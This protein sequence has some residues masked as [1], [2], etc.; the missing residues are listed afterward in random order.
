MAAEAVLPSVR[1]ARS[2]STW[3]DACQAR[4]RSCSIAAG[5]RERPGRLPSR[6]SRLPGADCAGEGPRVLAQ[7]RAA[8]ARVRGRIDD[9]GT[10]GDALRQRPDSRTAACRRASCDEADGVVPPAALLPESARKMT[11]PAT[12]ATSAAATITRTSGRRGRC[13]PPEAGA[14][15]RSPSIAVGRSPDGA[16]PRSS[17]RVAS[18]SPGGGRAPPRGGGDAN[19]VGAAGRAAG[20]RAAAEVVAWWRGHGCG[21]DG[22]GGGRRGA[23]QESQGADS[24]CGG[25]AAVGDI[26]GG[27]VDC[28][29]AGTTGNGAVD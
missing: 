5:S 23:Y 18:G 19:A 29:E 16:G 20:P 24:G 6:E 10:V 15:R 26:D 13:G 12:T 17:N 28:G 25:G 7:G 3:A 11:T 8:A 27:D 9:G 14:S 2:V 21:P 22:E 1:W 4:V